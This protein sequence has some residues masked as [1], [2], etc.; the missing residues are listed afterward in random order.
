MLEI[1]SNISCLPRPERRLILYA[2]LANSDTWGGGCA[3]LVRAKR[4]GD[5]DAVSVV[6]AVYSR[7]S[8]RVPDHLQ[9]FAC[10]E[11]GSVHYGAD[12]ARACCAECED[13]ERWDSMS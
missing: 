5:S 13:P 8:G 3:A 9:A 1:A 10:P 7:S 12:A 6:S 11:C 4:S 2:R